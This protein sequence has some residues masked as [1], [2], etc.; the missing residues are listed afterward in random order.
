[1][2]MA[3]EVTRVGLAGRGRAG[4]MVGARVARP[5]NVLGPAVLL[6]VVVAVA[7]ALEALRLGPCVLLLGLQCSTP[8]VL[9]SL[10]NG[11]M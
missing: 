1:M 11:Q 7:V 5:D 2:D 9:D 4:D 10:Y 3:S 6:A 8:V